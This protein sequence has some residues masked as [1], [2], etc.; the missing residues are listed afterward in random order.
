MRQTY[1]NSKGKKKRQ[2]INKTNI[3]NKNSWFKFYHVNH[4]TNCKCHKHSN[5][6]VTFLMDFFLK[7]APTIVYFLKKCTN[8]LNIKRQTI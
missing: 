1:L 3:K 6:N 2:Q 5:E 8:T 7:K 4:H